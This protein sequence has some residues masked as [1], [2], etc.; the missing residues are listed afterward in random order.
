[1]YRNISVLGDL[2]HPN[3]TLESFSGVGFVSSSRT[4]RSG[5]EMGLHESPNALRCVRLAHNECKVTVSMRSAIF[6]CREP[7][8]ALNTLQGRQHPP[9]NFK[10][11]LGFFLF[12]SYPPMTFSFSFRPPLSVSDTMRIDVGSSVHPYVCLFV[13]AKMYFPVVRR[14]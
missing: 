5:D 10:S 8:P 1:M 13:F 12:L 9:R 7:V 4:A 14:R 11:L 3:H 6:L 2:I